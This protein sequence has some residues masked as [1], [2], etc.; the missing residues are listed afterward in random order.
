MPQ[1]DRS[2]YDRGS[3]QC[4]LVL[5]LRS[6]VC[7]SA[8]SECGADWW[9]P[10]VHSTLSDSSQGTAT[11]SSD[12]GSQQ[13]L[14]L[15]ASALFSRSEQKTWLTVSSSPICYVETFGTEAC[16]LLMANVPERNTPG[17]H[18]NYFS[19]QAEQKDF[20]ESH[21]HPALVGNPMV[22]KANNPRLQLFVMQ[23]N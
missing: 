18:R 10:Q 21:L 8:G 11:S 2:Q 16:G 5:L 15:W 20:K 9:V 17:H 14:Y 12:P 13:S 1:Q 23:K 3:K 7:P 6:P 19:A 22:W 4:F